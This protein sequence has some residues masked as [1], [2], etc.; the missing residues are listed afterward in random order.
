MGKG[1]KERNSINIRYDNLISF[2]IESQS[3]K[4][5]ITNSFEF[6]QVEFI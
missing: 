6:K 3:V 5:N 4:Q 2:F 1:V